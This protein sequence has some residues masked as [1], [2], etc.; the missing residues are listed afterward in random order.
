MCGDDK[1]LGGIGAS[2]L[3]ADR[4]TRAT[5]QAPAGL[6]HSASIADADYND[7]DDEEF[8]PEGPEFECAG[9]YPE[10]A[11]E[12]YCPLWGTEECDW[13]CPHGGLAR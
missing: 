2:R 6:G 9:Y 13:E 8:D 3:A 12:F 11:G 4:A 7:L 5:P 10:P 1:D